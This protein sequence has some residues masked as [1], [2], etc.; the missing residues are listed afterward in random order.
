MTK[1][2]QLTNWQK[3]FLKLS[4]QTV[5]DEGKSKSTVLDGSYPEMVRNVK[6]YWYSAENASVFWEPAVPGTVVDFFYRLLKQNLSRPCCDPL[7]SLQEC[8]SYSFTEGV[9][10]GCELQVDLMQSIQILFK[11]TE[12][13]KLFRNTFEMWPLKDFIVKLPPL[14]WTVTKTV[15]TFNI[16]WITPRTRDHFKKFVLNITECE[17]L[18][19]IPITTEIEQTSTEWTVKPHCRYHMT[20]QA[21]YKVFTTPWSEEKSFDADADP[22][23][24]LYAVV[25][26]PLMLAGLTALT[27]VCCRE[28]IWK[29]NH[30]F[31]KVPQPRD[32]LTDISDSNNKSTVGYLYFPAEEEN[33]TIS[34]VLEPE[35]DKQ[36]KLCSCDNHQKTDESLLSSC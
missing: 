13:K 24:Y 18:M 12:N 4:V 22:N 36:T 3:T 17:T 1:T 6:V 10:T 8:S 16:N 23:A 14:E 20:M 11:G 21:V 5:C 25:L 27:F 33:C 7:P 32:F 35:I 34:L 30:I 31:P 2:S 28:H 9:R 19:A 29:K 15:N 26:I